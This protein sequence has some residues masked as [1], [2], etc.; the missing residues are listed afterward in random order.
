MPL[1]MRGTE[2]SRSLEWVSYYAVQLG[3]IV[4]N[5]KPNLDA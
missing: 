3:H 1:I 5:V 2:L 4:H